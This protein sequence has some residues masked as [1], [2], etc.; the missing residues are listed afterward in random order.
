MTAGASVSAFTPGQAAFVLA[1]RVGRLATADASGNPTVVPVCFALRDATIYIAL[2]EKPKR[3]PVERLRRV[4]DILAR[5]Q[6]TLLFDVY[7]EDWSQLGYVQAHGSADLARPGDADHALAVALLR[8]RYPRYRDMALEAAPLIR[9]RVERVTA[10]G[11]V[12]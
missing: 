8:E 5:P 3:V 4:R 2:D 7:H 10:W 12:G 1:Q 9:V 11:V 6:V